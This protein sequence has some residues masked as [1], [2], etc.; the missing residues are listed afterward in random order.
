MGELGRLQRQFHACVTAGAPTDDLIASGDLEIYARMYTSRLHDALADDYP[1]LRTALGDDRFHAIAAD[2]LRRHPPRSFT[3]RDAG[4]LLAEHLQGNPLAPSWATELA[5]LERARVEVFDGPDAAPLTRAEVVSLAAGLPDLLLSWVP[6]CMIVP[7]TWGVDELW[8]AIEDEQPAFEPA[9]GDRIVMVWRR[10]I[11]VLHRTVDPDEAHL[12][13]QIAI[14]ARFSDICEVLAGL[15]GD[16][17]GA[18][19]T[20]LLLRWL[21]AQALAGPTDA[22]R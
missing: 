12:A 10:D 3:L 11:A 17:A 7:L 21:D 18:R 8:S 1:K 14:G 5:A 20:E 19:A 2:Y 13:Q 4:A 22:P 6:S 15:H 16:A 9:R